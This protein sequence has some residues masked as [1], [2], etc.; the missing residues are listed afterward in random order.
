MDVSIFEQEAP[1]EDDVKLLHS[2]RGALES[3][4]KT[5]GSQFFSP[6]PAHG[7]SG[8]VNQGATCYLNSIV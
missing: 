2:V 1:S 3:T 7:L 6:K 5:R 8:L 4:I